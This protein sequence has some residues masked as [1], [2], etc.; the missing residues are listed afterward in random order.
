MKHEINLQVYARANECSELL[1]V[2]DFAIV[3]AKHF[4]S[5]FSQVT[6]TIVK[7]VEKPWEHVHVDG[8]P[9]KHGFKLG[10]EKHIQLRR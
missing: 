10:S 3:L 8:Q 6:T 9:L 1:S 5:F 2:E 7:I 4:T